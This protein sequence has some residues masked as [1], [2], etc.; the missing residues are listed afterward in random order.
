M[1]WDVLG[2]NAFGTLGFLVPMI[3]VAYLLFRKQELG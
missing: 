1:P 2:G 3:A